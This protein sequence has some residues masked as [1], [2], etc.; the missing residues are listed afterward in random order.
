[1]NHLRKTI[2]QYVAREILAQE[3]YGTVYGGFL[4]LER[5]IIKTFTPYGLSG[6]EAQPV[7]Q[8]FL[9]TYTR[10]RELPENL[11]IGRVL[12]AGQLEDNYLYVTY[13]FI[14]S[15][16]LQPHLDGYQRLTP[17]E[18]IRIFYEVA[19]ALDFVHEQRLVHGNLH[20]G[21]ILERQSHSR[22]QAVLIDF[23][24]WW[25]NPQL[26]TAAIPYMSPEQLAG[27][28]PTAQTDI[29]ALGKLLY[30]TLTGRVW[31]GSS[32]DAVDW[33]LLQNDVIAGIILR[34]TEPQPTSRYTSAG[35]LANALHTCLVQQTQLQQQN[36]SV[37]VMDKN[38]PPLLLDNE[39]WYENLRK[40][41]PDRGFES[42]DIYNI[43]YIGSD[44]VNDM[45]Q[46]PSE[47]G[48]EKRHVQLNRKARG[49]EIRPLYPNCWLGETDLIPNEN[50][51]WQ[52]QDK[53]LRIGNACL[54]YPPTHKP[55]N[56]PHLSVEQSTDVLDAGEKLLI[57]VRLRYDQPEDQETVLIQLISQD[58]PSAW[59]PTHQWNSNF[60]SQAILKE[61]E[62]EITPPRHPSSARKQYHFEVKV[63]HN[64][65]VIRDGTVNGGFRIKPFD[66]F[67]FTLTELGGNQYQALVENLGNTEQVFSLY[68]DTTAEN[69]QMTVFARLT[70]SEIKEYEAALASP[71]SITSE[72]K[73][74]FSLHRLRPLQRL[75]GVSSWQHAFMQRTG[76]IRISQ[77]MNMVKSWFAF[78]KQWQT[79]LK[80]MG[81]GE[82]DMPNAKMMRDKLPTLS[83]LKPYQLPLLVKIPPGKSRVVFLQSGGRPVRSF[84]QKLAGETV[85]VPFELSVYPATN[86][87]SVQKQTHIHKD[88]PFIGYWLRLFFI[89]LFSTI[90]FGVGALSDQDRDGSIFIREL[91]WGTDPRVPDTDGDGVLDG[92]E[93]GFYRTIGDEQ[94]ITTNPLSSDTDGDGLSDYQELLQGSNPNLVDTDGDGIDDNWE[95]CEAGDLTCVLNPL[96]ANDR[97]FDK[98]GLTNAQE[99]I[100]G[101]RFDRLDT[102]NDGLS[103]AYELSYGTDPLNPDSD[104]D[105]LLDGEEELILL[106]NPNRL[107]TDGDSLEDAL[108]VRDLM[109]NPL[110]ADVLPAG[111]AF[112]VQGALPTATPFALPTAV[113]QIVVIPPTP[114]SIPAPTP[115]VV[116]QTA[117]LNPAV[118][119]YL[120]TDL[121]LA[122]IT[123]REGKLFIGDDRKQN[124][125]IGFLFFELNDIP[126]TA[127][128]SS[129]LLEAQL[130]PF[131]LANFK[132][133][134]PLTVEVI[135]L[136][137][138]YS[139][140]KPADLLQP[141]P[142]RYE[143]A[144]TDSPAGL[145][146]KMD[147]D[148]VK[149]IQGG[150]YL[151]LRFQFLVPNDVDNEE[152]VIS[153]QTV[154]ND[155][156]PVLNV[157]YS[158]S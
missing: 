122:N 142:F 47:L 37:A 73:S 46:L 17:D 30:H 7:V 50:V 52:D 144:L 106:T 102:D 127:T 146:V 6:D 55:L 99:K 49:W 88:A 1:M 9:N 16:T 71:T 42:L 129:L 87:E 20:V 128:I 25:G 101:T 56:L 45:I 61:F 8:A 108:E 130:D 114:T 24:F 107:D 33:S 81:T 97:D 19:R 34:A 95:I 112:M 13:E 14:D 143:V 82:E 131:V 136:S 93:L 120:Q 134:T 104:F 79:A 118:V 137:Q 133:L 12:D 151:L 66:E 40:L 23:G 4:G 26:L 36:G 155:T 69:Q 91:Y 58:I 158:N 135:A 43:I 62:F 110:I 148:V 54:R 154:T 90:L 3:P 70:D 75:P 119:G 41:D 103:D 21:A 124:Q 22:G 156:T 96:L 105:G 85:H 141:T 139:A 116:E 65:R 117:V 86:K 100:Q 138:G 94:V 113:P 10:L 53:L 72:N 67:L 39:V 132:T 32:R 157:V 89:L 78:G 111:V 152:D 147:D 11:Y 63:T 115:F 150:Q 48:V 44:S 83:F 35:D 60:S 51:L 31:Q 149:P 121:A 125:Y 109:S 84:A 59:I 153:I 140:L 15:S 57:T 74:L 5:A 126:E 28:P 92:V 76:L 77:S 98:D 2:G 68:Q 29:Y 145:F 27:Q 80:Q 18:I 64:G 123:K 38:M